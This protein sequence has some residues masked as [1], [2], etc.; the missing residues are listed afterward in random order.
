MRD[1]LE[2]VESRDALG[3]EELR[4]V[5]AV[6]LQRGGNHIAG[7]NFLAAG[8]LDVE[9]GG[10]KHA[11]ERESLLGFLL[12]APGELL[13]GVLKVLVQIATQLRHVR[14]TRRQDPLAV[15][16]VSER[17]QQVLERQVGMTP[18]CCLAIRHRENDFQSRTKHVYFY[19]YVARPMVSTI[20]S[21]TYF[22]LPT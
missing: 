16:I 11:T 1:V 5:R 2:D 20:R 6:L 21:L 18:R 9:H 15:G 17:V 4:R 14:A 19:D 8:A 3:S 12:L 7:M 10:L 22:S 13:D